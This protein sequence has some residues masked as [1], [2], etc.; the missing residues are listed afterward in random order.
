MYGVTR[1]SGAPP[2]VRR[3]GR[4]LL[5]TSLAALMLGCQGA[6]LTVDERDQGPAD[7]GA[8]DQRLEDHGASD[9]LDG[10][11]LGAPELGEPGDQGLG[12]LDLPDGCLPKTLWRDEDGDGFGGATSAR[13]CPGER[14]WA[15]VAG[16]CDDADPSRYPG[17]MRR[18]G[19][20]GDCDGSVD[21]DVNGDGVSDLDPPSVS[22]DPRI[23]RHIELP[24]VTAGEPFSITLSSG[25]ITPQATL[26]HTP[27][28][29]AALRVDPVTG[30]ISGQ[31]RDPG[32]YRFFVSVCAKAPADPGDCASPEHRRL[33][34]AHL[35]VRDPSAQAPSPPAQPP[36]QG[37]WATK[38]ARVDLDVTGV[39]RDV[40]LR[41]L[42]QL[43]AREPTPE[44]QAE[45]AA[46]GSVSPMR[47]ITPERGDQVAP[48]PLPL[49]I[50][51]HGNGYHWDD[52]DALGQRLASHGLI[53]MIPQFVNGFLGACGGGPSTQQRVQFGVKA[54]EW[55]MAESASAS[56]PLR[57][58]VDP[59]RLILVG[60]SWGGA[61]AQ[62][63]MPVLG[64]RAFVILDPVSLLNNVLEWSSC[65]TNLFTATS[66]R[67]HL[68][69]DYRATSAPVLTINAGRSGFRRTLAEHR[70][71]YPWAPLIHVSLRDAM[72]EDLL[73]EDEAR[74]W[75]PPETCFDAARLD[76]VHAEA[77]RWI[78][79]L[80]R[81]YAL[82]DLTQDARLHGLEALEPSGAL[83]TTVATFRP[84]A[85]CAML[86]QASRLPLGPYSAG[87]NAWG[88]ST[89]WAAEDARIDLSSA[90]RAAIVP[91]A[92]GTLNVFAQATLDYLSRDEH[93]AYR[94]FVASQLSQPATLQ[95][96]LN[97]ALDARRYSALCVDGVIEGPPTSSCQPGAPSD[98]LEPI[99]LEVTLTLAN[100]QQISQRLMGQTSHQLPQTLCAPLDALRAPLDALAS[101]SVSVAPSPRGLRSVALSS[102]RLVP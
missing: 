79:R 88:G 35:T 93:R 9:D 47:L 50:I 68:A 67:D 12:E 44:R 74:R 34:L 24:Q 29:A 96:G 89:S 28:F 71:L 18:A 26:I 38:L 77:A 8:R 51:L 49:V 57:G 31:L 98:P 1:A 84:C 78:L 30:Q 10:R 27:A 63:S 42:P 36:A 61:A 13:R 15:Q 81:R 20:D 101:V 52:Y 32:V 90:A 73:D 43:A 83:L 41:S 91:N 87:P 54:L 19:V 6:S 53:V 25:R 69:A 33:D 76:A 72:H 40:D 62:W 45:T 100:G 94:H 65:N 39:L 80:V 48:G 66:G 37:P 16:D 85:D 46:L 23:Q 22:F 3:A 97:P 14:G 64:A 55:A 2:A 70:G 17:A 21:F 11:D 56:S 59:S 95:V 58:R 99:E 7:Q 5:A 86:E 92:D 75:L 60:H 82:G 102:L 4:L